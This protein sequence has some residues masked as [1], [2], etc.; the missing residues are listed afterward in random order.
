[1]IVGLFGLAVAASPVVPE[2][3]D[4]FSEHG[5]GWWVDEL[6]RVDRLPGSVAVGWLSQVRLVARTRGLPLFFGMSLSAQS[7]GLRGRLGPLAGQ[8]AVRTRLGLPDGAWVGFAGWRGPVRIGGS[9]VVASN[10]SWADPR[11]DVWRVLPAVSV[12]FGR[13]PDDLW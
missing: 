4:V 11:W 13:R 12:G 7:I 2:R 9:L 5:A 10:A 3:I 6:P 1:M 8:V